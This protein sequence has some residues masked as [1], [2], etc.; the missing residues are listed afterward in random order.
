MVYLI[1]ATMVVAFT[2]VLISVLIIPK[3]KE[4]QVH[5][6]VIVYV[7]L[8]IWWPIQ[9]CVY[10]F[11][12]DLIMV[13]ALPEF[14]AVEGACS[15]NTEGDKCDGEGAGEVK[16]EEPSQDSQQSQNSSV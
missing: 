16:D 15:G 2:T 12:K 7:V 8:I 9:Y 4:L 1:L 11:Y 6:F 3:V 5:I 13:V 10:L 14:T